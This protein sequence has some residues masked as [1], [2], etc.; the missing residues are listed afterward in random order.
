MTA[1]LILAV[2]VFA[3]LWLLASVRAYRI[4]RETSHTAADH[5]N[6]S[7]HTNSNMIENQ[8]TAT[9]TANGNHISNE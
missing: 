4:A 5:S 1:A 8:N 3:V 9:S 7:G 6:L 2:L